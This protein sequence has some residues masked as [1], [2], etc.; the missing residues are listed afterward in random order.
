[1]LPTNFGSL[2]DQRPELKPVLKLV[3]RWI[4]AHPE[5]DVLDPRKLAVDLRNVPSRDLTMAL[6]SLIREGIFSA[7]YMVETPSGVLSEE[8]FNDIHQI[9]ETVHDRWN[10][11]FETADAEIVQVLAAPHHASTARRFR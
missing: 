2:A 1:M 8:K 6:T 10:R 9:P 3:A 11:S 5:W 4:K 7:L